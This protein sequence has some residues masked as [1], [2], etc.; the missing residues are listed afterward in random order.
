MDKDEAIEHLRERIKK[1]DNSDVDSVWNA[2]TASLVRDV[3]GEEADEYSWIK[4]R[5]PLSWSLDHNTDQAIKLKAK[6]AAITFI[7]GCI[8]TVQRNGVHKKQKLNFI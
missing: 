3:L 2:L 4:N 5:K 8:D 6:N 1:L 7:N